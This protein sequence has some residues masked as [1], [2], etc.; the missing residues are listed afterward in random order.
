VATAHPKRMKL[1]A[2]Q[3]VAKAVLRRLEHRER[4]HIR[5][6]LVGIG[7]V[8]HAGNCDVLAGVLRRLFDGGAAAEHDQ[9]GGGHLLTARAEVRAHPFQRR[10]RVGQLFRPAVSDC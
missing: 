5:Q 8:R 4:L 10:Q 6:L 7:A 9:V 1:L 3:T 2:L